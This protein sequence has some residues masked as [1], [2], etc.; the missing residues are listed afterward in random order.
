MFYT[1][2]RAAGRGWEGGPVGQYL[3]MG[4]RVGPT[5]ALEV[6][7]TRRLSVQYQGLFCANRFVSTSL[8]PTFPTGLSSE[9][10]RYN[11]I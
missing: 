2:I 4:V 10:S 5:S 3:L 7:G 9:Y 1:R 6:A 8:F 11:A